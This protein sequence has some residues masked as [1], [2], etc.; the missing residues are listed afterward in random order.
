M[1]K[2]LSTLWKA[3]WLSHPGNRPRHP[4]AN[5]FGSKYEPKYKYNLEVANGWLIF[6]TFFYLVPGSRFEFILTT[7]LTWYLPQLCSG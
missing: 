5:V 6:V 1:E 4:L 3:T 7:T 2:S